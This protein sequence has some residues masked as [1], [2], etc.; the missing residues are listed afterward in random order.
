ML[1]SFVWSLNGDLWLPDASIFAEIV[2]WY[3]NTFF[4][5]LSSLTQ[6]NRILQL[7]LELLIGTIV[8]YLY[9]LWQIEFWLF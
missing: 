1:F 5:H 2:G 4:L 8:I 7:Q 6:E 9:V 3:N